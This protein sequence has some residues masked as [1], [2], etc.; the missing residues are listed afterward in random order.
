M[1]FL[2]KT[3][4]TSNKR[5]KRST[6]PNRYPG[7]HVS[8]PESCR[9]TK[10]GSQVSVNLLREVAEVVQEN[11]DF[12][13]APLSTRLPDLIPHPEELKPTETMNSF[14]GKIALLVDNL[15]YYFIPN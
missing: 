15:C 8:S 2:M 5:A 3:G 9:G 6:S 1:V 11:Q 7:S 4:F 14:K 10:D 13:D 12:L